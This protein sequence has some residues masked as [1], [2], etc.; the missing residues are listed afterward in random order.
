MANTIYDLDEPGPYT[1]QALQPSRYNKKKHLVKINYDNYNLRN[2]SSSVSTAELPSI[3]SE[4]R[5]W[6]S[7][8]P[9]VT[10]KKNK[11]KSMSSKKNEPEIK[12]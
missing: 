2:S 10:E 8:K 1:M 6:Y 12:S 7:I 11:R 3:R 9:I 5:D 4:Q